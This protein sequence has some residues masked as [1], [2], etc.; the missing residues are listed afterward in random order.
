VLELATSL[1]TSVKH[2]TFAID[3]PADVRADDIQA[4]T[5]G[6]NF[7]VSLLNNAFSVELPFLGFCNIY[8]ALAALATGHSLGIGTTDMKAGLENCKLLSQRYEIF[9]HGS[10]TFINDAYNANPNSMREALTTL[11]AYPSAG[12]RIFVI[13]DMLELG[14]LS[15]SAHTQLGQEISIK[16]IDL[17]ITVGEMTALTAKGARDGGMKE[18]RIFAFDTRED[19][20]EF[21]GKNSRP[22]DCLL[23]KGSRGSGMEKVMQQLIQ[24]EAS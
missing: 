17:L 2:L 1:R 8:N 19:A 4:T 6:H 23:F 11:A 7:T 18:D 9:Q 13:G 22:G 20:S 5:G 3:H 24:P 15:I 10:M 12:R 14:D 16:P 21:L